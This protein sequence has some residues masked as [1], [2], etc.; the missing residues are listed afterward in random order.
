MTV[1]STKQ[2]NKA[3]L[4][5]FLT[6]IWGIAGITI[7]SLRGLGSSTS[8]SLYG[9]FIVL[10]GLGNIIGGL[11]V[12]IGHKY[13]YVIATASLVFTA[14]AD[15]LTFQIGRI[16][17]DLTALGLIIQGFLGFNPLE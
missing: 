6:F 16:F 2:K 13:G 14:F 11:G 15:F 12:I 4:A 1:A 8:L 17:L 9:I 10:I 3:K 7:V 5:G